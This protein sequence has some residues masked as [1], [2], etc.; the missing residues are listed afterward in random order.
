MNTTQDFLVALGSNLPAGADTPSLTLRK[1]IEML[2]SEGIDVVAESRFFHT[3]CFPEGAGPDYVNAA[4]LCRTDLSPK[5]ILQLLHKVESSF[6]RVRTSRWAGRTLDLDLIAVDN[7]ILPDRTT[8][9]HWIDLPISAQMEVAPE[10]LILPH[11]RMQ[12]RAFVLIPLRDI[13]PGWKH[14]ILGRTV[15]ELCADLP[16]DARNAVVPL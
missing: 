3:P 15:A 11:P 14:P 8:V 1:A 12:D 13:A 6:G 2:S 16:E 7:H 5:E 9:Q 10:Q 4:L